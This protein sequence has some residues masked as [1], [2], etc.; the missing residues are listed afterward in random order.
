[1]VTVATA[2]MHRHHLGG[3]GGGPAGAQP[4]LP[5]HFSSLFCYKCYSIVASY[6]CNPVLL[7]AKH[8]KGRICTVCAA[9]EL[10]SKN[11]FRVHLSVTPHL[12]SQTDAYAE[13]CTIF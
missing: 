5:S 3:G 4:P 6:P 2:G 10:I 9:T 7:S 8:I 1:M 12:Q 11:K 13:V